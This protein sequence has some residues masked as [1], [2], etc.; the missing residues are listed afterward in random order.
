MLSNSLIMSDLKMVR[1][2]IVKE[3]NLR[4]ATPMKKT[5]LVLLLLTLITLPLVA[6][7]INVP[8]VSL[9]R[10]PGI[11]MGRFPGMNMGSGAWL[12]WFVF[13]V[14]SLWRIAVSTILGWLV[15]TLLPLHTV[16]ASDAAEREPLRAILYG[17]LGYAATIPATIVLAITLIG[18]PLI[19]VLWLAIALAGLFGQAALGL[20]VGKA[21]NKSL[22]QD[23]NESHQVL[24]GLAT[25]GVLTAIPGAG[26]L[27]SLFTGLLGFGAAV[28]TQFGRNAVV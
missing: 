8:G 16:R 24:I 23:F 28:W 22:N 14:F 6:C 19:P 1:R 27:V 12:R 20:L 9:G 11:N 3:I 25:I 26:G 2:V 18:I 21:L 7:S 15:F 5:V 17:L 4:E 13:P 10:F